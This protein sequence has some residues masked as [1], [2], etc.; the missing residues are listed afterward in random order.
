M[1]VVNRLPSHRS[2]QLFNNA[3]TSVPAELGQLSSLKWLYVRGRRS[4]GTTD[5]PHSST[6]TD[7]SGCRSRWIVC[8]RRP[9]FS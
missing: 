7:S 2:P 1:V 6:T 9:R 8:Q 3:L 4:L 5:A